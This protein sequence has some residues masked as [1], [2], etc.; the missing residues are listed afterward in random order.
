MC[1]LL[2]HMH[3]QTQLHACFTNKERFRNLSHS[4]ARSSA[5][6]GHHDQVSPSSLV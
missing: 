5:V 3:C 1:C 6:L 2:L 4:T